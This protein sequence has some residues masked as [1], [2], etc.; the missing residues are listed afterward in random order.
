MRAMEKTG[1]HRHVRLVNVSSE[2]LSDEWPMPVSVLFIDGDHRYDA[3]KRD[4]ECWRGKLAPRAMVVLDDASDPSHGPGQLGQE[5]VDSGTFVREAAIGKMVCLRKCPFVV[6]A[7]VGPTNWQIGTG[8]KEVVTKENRILLTPISKSVVQIRLINLDRSTDRLA[9]FQKRNAHLR[10]VVRFTAIDG[11][12][13]DREKLIKEDIITRDCSY[14]NGSLGCAMSH[15]TLWRM[16]VDEQRTITIAEDDAI[17]SYTF[18]GQAERVLALLPEDWDVILWGWNFDAP[19]RIDMLPGVS[20]AT[21]RCNQ[22]HM[23]QNIEQFQRLQIAPVLVK[24][25][26]SWGTMC[27]T[28]SPKGAQALLNICLPLRPT[29]ID[30]PGYDR[31]FEAKSLDAMLNAAHTSLK[32]FLCIPPLV[33]SENRHKVSTIVGNP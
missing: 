2:F 19:L 10:D 1:L 8:T 18:E 5:L 17:F 4:F 30:I 25:L 33:V 29:L 11:Q 21:V 24:V 31:R 26:H 13:L 20:G 6:E 28:V 32:S 23:R 14:D 15:I 9:E 16:A 22:E 12:L 27:C 3:A 7:E